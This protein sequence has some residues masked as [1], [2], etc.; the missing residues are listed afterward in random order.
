MTKSDWL[1]AAINNIRAAQASICCAGLGAAPSFYR[2]TRVRRTLEQ[3]RKKELRHEH[4]H[5]LR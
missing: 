1:T 4:L 5:S 3:R 2:L